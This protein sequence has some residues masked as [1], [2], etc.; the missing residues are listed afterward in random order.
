[1]DRATRTGCVRRV[2]TLVAVASAI[3]LMPFVAVAAPA[4]AEPAAPAWVEIEI[5]AGDG[6]AIHGP[7]GHGYWNYPRY[8]GYPHHPRHPYRPGRPGCG[9]WCIWPG[10]PHAGSGSGSAY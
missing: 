1:M 5:A 9:G 10:L 8:P 2:V 4:L 3:A 6:E 7:Y